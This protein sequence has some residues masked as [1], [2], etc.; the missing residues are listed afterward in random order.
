MGVARMAQGAHFF[1]HVLWTA[2]FS[3]A[4]GMMLAYVFKVLP[5]SE[6]KGS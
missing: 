1:S 2:W 5:Y 3:W 6:Q 4:I